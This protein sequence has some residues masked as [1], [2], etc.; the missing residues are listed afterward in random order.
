MTGLHAFHGWLDPARGDRFAANARAIER[1]RVDR[2]RAQ[3]D[4]SRCV[5][6]GRPLS[7]G[8]AALARREAALIAERLAKEHELALRA[9]EEL[10]NRWDARGYAHDARIG[11]G[12]LAAIRMKLSQERTRYLAAVEQDRPRA[13]EERRRRR[14]AKTKALEADIAASAARR[15]RA[16][17][18][19]ENEKAELRRAARIA[20]EAAKERARE[21]RL[22]RDLEHQR[23]LLAGDPPQG[24]GGVVKENVRPDEAPEGDAFAKGNERAA[25]EVS[26]EE[27]ASDRSADLDDTEDRSADVDAQ[28]AAWNAELERRRAELEEERAAVRDTRGEANRTGAPPSRGE[29]APVRPGGNEPEAFA[30]A[31]VAAEDAS[32]SVVPPHARAATLR[33]LLSHIH[34]KR[35]GGGLYAPAGRT[36]RPGTQP[37]AAVA[38]ALREAVNAVEKVD[39]GGGAIRGSLDDVAAAV[40]CDAVGALVR[41][42]PAGDGEPLPLSFLRRSDFMVST[43]GL[44]PATSSGGLSEAD[45]LWLA[46]ELRGEQTDAGAST[47]GALLEHFAELVDTSA[48]DAWHAAETMADMMVPAELSRGDGGGDNVLQRG[49]PEEMDRRAFVSRATA[50]LRGLLSCRDP[51][52]APPRGHVP[53]WRRGAMGRAGEG[54]GGAQ[55]TGDQGQSAAGRAAPGERAAKTKQT[56]GPPPMTF[57]DGGASAAQGA[58]TGRTMLGG[59]SG[60]SFITRPGVRRANVNAN[61]G[62]HLPS[63]SSALGAVSTR[64]LDSS[65]EL[66]AALRAPPPPPPEK[67]KEK[68][69]ERTTSPGSP[70]HSAARAR[71][72]GRSPSPPTSP[73]KKPLSPATLA[74]QQRRAQQQQQQE[75]ARQ[76]KEQQERQAATTRREE[77][78]RAGDLSG[79]GA[80]GSGQAASQRRRR[81]GGAG[82]NDIAGPTKVGSIL[83]RALNDDSDTSEMASSNSS[84]LQ[85]GGGGYGGGNA[86]DMDVS[87][88]FDF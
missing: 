45:A 84:R 1:L 55:R 73:E 25:A 41:A 17:A 35:Y 79:G 72:R 28:R 59:P 34:A 24:G 57:G 82:S 42:I 71:A 52:A 65:D 6:E 16:R 14:E 26:G 33:A 74:A 60:T 49:L 86:R 32:S 80:G 36:H 2:R 67:E 85:G 87:D 83:S 50:L 21:A 27:E 62:R 78:T 7:M 12:A 47:F 68:E 46:A 76:E 53:F 22:L 11:D 77:A 20:G 15:E 38:A 4:I 19:F 40:A 51:T 18:D 5:A 43:A 61:K 75:K 70:V 64:A 48:L 58:S 63:A 13:E 9:L 69:K 54:A 56:K 88:D 37:G 39:G 31:S 44:E 81:A 8:A 66:E 30:R 23:A 3:D 29:G 10:L